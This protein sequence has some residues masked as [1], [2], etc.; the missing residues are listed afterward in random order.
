[1]KRIVI[2]LFLC[3][4]IYT[5]YAQIEKSLSFGELLTKTTDLYQVNKIDSAIIV[6]EY[7]FENFPEEYQQS[8]LILGSLYT[9]AGKNSKAIAIWKSGMEK[10][11]NYHLT[12]PGYLNYYKENADFMNL[13]NMEKARLG[14]AHIVHEVILPETYDPQNLY[15]LLF[16]FHGNS[17]NIDKSKKSWISPV[18]KKDYISIFVQSYI[19]YNNTDYVWKANDE[20]T[21]KEFKDLYSKILATYPV[22]TSNIIFA[23]MSA[24][25]NLV[26]EFAFS[27][28][29]PMSGLVLNCPVVPVEI[30]DEHISQ[31]VKKN[32]RIG[33]ITGEKD[34]AL[35]NQKSLIMRVKEEG[36]QSKITINEEIG[37]EFGQEFTIQLDEYLNWIKKPEGMQQDM[38]FFETKDAYFG[39]EPPGLNPEVFAPGIVSDST[40]AEHCQIAISPIQSR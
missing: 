30:T 38:S 32:K 23:G 13:L 4:F 24:G 6:M 34:F 9:R 21:E 36:G 18:M 25:G 27:E 19:H 29:V 15:P 14:A 10:G 40:W 7:A 26:L 8:T 20:K 33:I 2:T 39:Q 5:S 1:M 35:D 22:D 12:S 3:A 37:H 28:L 16:I 31:F 17:R 11:Y